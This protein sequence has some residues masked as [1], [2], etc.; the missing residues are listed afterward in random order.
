LKQKQLKESS[1]V[2]AHELSSTNSQKELDE[3]MNTFKDMIEV[4]LSKDSP[5]T[6]KK[7]LLSV[8]TYLIEFKHYLF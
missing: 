5:K 4:M 8:H 7:A 6:V 1:N 3:L 2:D